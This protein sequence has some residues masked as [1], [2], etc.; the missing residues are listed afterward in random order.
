V[1]GQLGE[2]LIPTLIRDIAEKSESGLL[3]VTRGKAIKAIFFEGGLPK[4]AISNLANEQLEQK[5]LKDGLATADQIELARQAAGKTNQLGPALVQNGFLTDDLMRKT[6]RDQVMA[7][8]LSLFEWDQ[9][10]YVF[11]SRIRTNHEITLDCSAADILLEGARHAAALHPIADTI[12]PS[13]GVVIRPHLNGSRLD[14]GKLMPI[15]SY[16][17]S[18]IDSPTAVSEVGALSGIPEEDAHRAICALVAAGLLRLAGDEQEDHDESTGNDEAIIADLREEVGRRLHFYTN[19]DFYEVLEIT[20]QSTS[21]DIKTAYY[22]L[23][24]KFHPDRYHQIPRDSEL[25]SQLEAVFARLSQAY[26]TLKEPALRAGYDTQLRKPSGPLKRHQKPMVTSEP[27]VE[28]S[29]QPDERSQVSATRPTGDLKMPSAPSAPATA[30]AS[31]AAPPEAVASE[32]RTAEYYFQQ[33][34]ARFDRKEYHAAVHLLREAVKLDS[35]R[36]Q[37]HLHLGVALINNPR[38]RRE[39]E[40]HLSKAAELDPYNAQV[41]AKLGMLYKEAGLPKKSEHYFREA[42]SIDPE[43]RVALRELGVDKSKD[44]GRLGSFKRLFKK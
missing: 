38:T 9:G 23:A 27:R 24:K 30:A 13:D 25:R 41:R 40:Q 37:Y 2:K 22:G 17:L 28:H 29:P 34:R 7:I 10:D 15:E 3:R 21:G 1:Q 19:A 18:R 39:A 4:F 35:T 8:I 36:P 14:T 11:D 31:V 6:V 16:V 5:L 43:N 33:G 42:L 26:D 20:R 12:A 32:G 44:A